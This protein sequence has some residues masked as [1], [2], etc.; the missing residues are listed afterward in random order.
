MMYRSA[1]LRLYRSGTLLGGSVRGYETTMVLVARKGQSGFL[2][3]HSWLAGDSL[4]PSERGQ[5]K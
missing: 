3:P 4:Y 2:E 1:F 5:R